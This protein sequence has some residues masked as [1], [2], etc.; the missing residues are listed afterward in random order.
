MSKFVDI[1]IRSVRSINF[2]T[3]EMYMKYHHAAEENRREETD[4]E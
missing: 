2:P 3:K 4:A 1:F